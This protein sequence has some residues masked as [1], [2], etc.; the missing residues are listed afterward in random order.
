MKKT[1]LILFSALLLS[2]ATN[3][4]SFRMPSASPKVNLIH[5]FS[6]SSIELEYFRPSMKGRKIFGEM[7]PFGL[8]W[9]TGAN[10]KTIITFGEDVSFGGQKVSAGKYSIYTI[11]GKDSWTV[12][13]NSALVNESESK[14]YEPSKDVV[15]LQ[16]KPVPTEQTYE[17]FT[18]EFS[19]ISDTSAKLNIIWENTRVAVQITAN[20]NERILTYLEKELNGSKPPYQQASYYYYNNNH[21]LE[22]ALEY[23]DKAILSNKDAFWM[24][25]HKAKIYLKLGDKAQAI[26]SAQAAADITKGTD[27]EFEYA[28][29]LDDIK[30][31]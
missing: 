7:I 2:I 25:S 6:T 22:K 14:S 1:Y 26:K 8:P 31:S 27:Y 28:K 17:T 23:A 4:Q 3:A 20:N 21:K 16:V 9:R 10:G 15:R 19:D 30:K 12:V 18:I 5:Q 11:P 24:H 13:L 29:K